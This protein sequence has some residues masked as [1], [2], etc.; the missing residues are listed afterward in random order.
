[1]GDRCGGCR[2]GEWPPAVSDPR[3]YAPRSESC[4]S[5]FV[6]LSLLSLSSW[7]Q[8][9]D[10][11]NRLLC[12]CVARFRSCEHA[13]VKPS[14]SLL[15]P[16]RFCLVFIKLVV[17]FSG[18]H[19]EFRSWYWLKALDHC[20]MNPFLCLLQVSEGER[21]ERRIGPQRKTLCSILDTF[22]STYLM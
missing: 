16:T 4:R 20:E 6:V 14:R 21:L 9:R 10:V 17:S 13:H 12:A 2:R 19:V 22:I 3:V 1:M 15:S 18:N 11:T 5:D 7:A 8:V